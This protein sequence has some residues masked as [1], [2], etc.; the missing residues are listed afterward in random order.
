MSAFNIHQI[1]IVCPFQ[2]CTVEQT[3]M[4]RYDTKDMKKCKWMQGRGVLDG[5]CEGVGV[6]CEGVGVGVIGEK[7]WGGRREACLSNPSTS[8]QYTRQIRR[9]DQVAKLP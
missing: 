2:P 4:N 9:Q 6:K 7:G 8:C 3:L 1:P 5:G